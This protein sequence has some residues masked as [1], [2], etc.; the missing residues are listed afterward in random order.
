MGCCKTNNQCLIVTTINPICHDC[1]AH[2]GTKIEV[3]ISLKSKENILFAHN[4][5]LEQNTNQAFS[6]LD[7]QSSIFFPVKGL[8]SLFFLQSI[9]TFIVQTIISAVVGAFSKE[10]QGALKVS[11]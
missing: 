9:L 10:Q 1:P 8:V 5:I 7:L 4:F 11:L 6:C 2:H 3:L